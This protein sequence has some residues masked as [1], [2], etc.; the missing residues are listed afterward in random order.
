MYFVVAV[1]YRD[2]FLTLN[3]DSVRKSKTIPI[4]IKPFII[5]TSAKALCDMSTAIRNLSVFTCHELIASEI[6]SRHVQLRTH[7]LEL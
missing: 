3:D 2:D 6:E 5:R 4:I 7:S 1:L